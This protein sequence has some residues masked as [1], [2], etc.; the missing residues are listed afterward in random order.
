MEPPRPGQRLLPLLLIRDDGKA[1]PGREARASFRFQ[2]GHRDRL[3]G[4][5]NQ[6]RCKRFG[7]PDDLQGQLHARLAADCTIVT[8][9]DQDPAGPRSRSFDYELGL[10]FAPYGPRP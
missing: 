3:P 4:Y 10:M 5:G 6:S 1:R 9:P 8:R 2:E 7:L